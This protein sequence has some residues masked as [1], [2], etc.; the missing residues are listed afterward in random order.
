MAQQVKD[1]RKSESQAV[2]V[3]IWVATLL[4]TKVSPLRVGAKWQ[5]T[6][7]TQ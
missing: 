6:V 4:S 5:E 7:V 2:T 3:W 1:I